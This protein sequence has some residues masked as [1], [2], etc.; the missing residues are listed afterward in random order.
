MVNGLYRKNF[1]LEEVEIRSTKESAFKVQSQIQR[2]ITFAVVKKPCF[3]SPG[4][5]WQT[6]HF[7]NKNVNIMSFFKAHGQILLVVV[8]N[9]TKHPLLILCSNRTQVMDFSYYVQTNMSV[10]RGIMQCISIHSIHN[11]EILFFSDMYI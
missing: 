8:H 5:L 9:I 6:C 2:D 11:E 1:L 7:Y 4:P 10:E 3:G